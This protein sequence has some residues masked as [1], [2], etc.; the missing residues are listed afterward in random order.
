MSLLPSLS[1]FP[2]L[3][4]LPSIYPSF[5]PLIWPYGPLYLC[6]GQHFSQRGPSGNSVLTC[7]VVRQ[8]DVFVRPDAVVAMDPIILY[9][10]VCASVVKA[11]VVK[12]YPF[13]I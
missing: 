6:L 12:D 13:N 4:F 9:E 3:S 2:L 7:C 1:T 10:D 8:G 5:F 11:V